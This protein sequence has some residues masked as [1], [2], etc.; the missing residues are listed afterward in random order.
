MLDAVQQKHCNKFNSEVGAIKEELYSHFTGRQNQICDFCFTVNQG[1][2]P[3]L[4]NYTTAYCRDRIPVKGNK[5]MFLT[6]FL[7]RDA[8]T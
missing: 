1:F 5:D 2:Y 4:Y 7:G 8:T 3:R 6:S